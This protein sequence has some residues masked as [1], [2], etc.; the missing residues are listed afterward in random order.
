MICSCGVRRG[1]VGGGA[2]KDL[3]AETIAWRRTL[4]MGCL[5]SLVGALAVGGLWGYFLLNVVAPREPWWVILGESFR[6]VVYVVVW[7]MAGAW[8]AM[9]LAQRW[10]YARGVYR[11]GRCGR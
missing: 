9:W 8:G 5:G 2:M 1:E 7:G 10:Y 6:L 4:G 11:C 3:P